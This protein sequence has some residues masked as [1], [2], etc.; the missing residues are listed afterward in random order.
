MPC[1]GQCCENFTLVVDGKPLSWAEWDGGSGFA[2]N[3]LASLA[4]KGKQDG[5]FECKM[6]DPVTRLCRDYEKR[7]AACRQFPFQANQNG[8][9]GNQCQHCDYA[10]ETKEPDR[11]SIG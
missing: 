9:V 11:G 4:V 5:R 2:S 10:Q 8:V 1:S 7:P 6:F 3:D